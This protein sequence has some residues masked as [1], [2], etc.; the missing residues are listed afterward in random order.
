LPTSHFPDVL[1]FVGYTHVELNACWLRLK[2]ASQQKASNSETTVNFK[3]Q[4]IRIMGEDGVQAD[5]ME[6]ELPGC[7]F[8][9]VH[10]FE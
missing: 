5:G 2:E 7:C 6:K 10:A 9:N 1:H 4:R 3:E 8:E